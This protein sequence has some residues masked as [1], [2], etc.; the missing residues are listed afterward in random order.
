LPWQKSGGWLFLDQ[1][2][3]S[4]IEIKEAGI[5]STNCSA[6]QRSVRIEEVGFLLDQP[7][8]LII[9]QAFS[10]IK[11][12]GWSFYSTNQK[13]PWFFQPEKSQGWP[14]FNQSKPEL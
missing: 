2:H 12:G 14:F 11:Q 6:A 10:A 7:Q 3:R 4:L 9:F 1:P 13:V 8:R 5:F